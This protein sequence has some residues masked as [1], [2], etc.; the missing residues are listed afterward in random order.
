MA[1][2]NNFVIFCD[3]VRQEA[4]GK[5]ILVG[6]YGEAMVVQGFPYS[7][8]LAMFLTLYHLPERINLTSEVRLAS[9]AILGR[10]EMQLETQDGITTAQVPLPH[11]SLSLS[12]ADYVQL[13]IGVNSANLELVGQLSIKAGSLT[14]PPANL[15]T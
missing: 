4:N 13:W 14:A 7:A 11:I 2:P 15:F 5:F 9:G 12:S 10:I 1:Y 6:C 3:S 8:Q